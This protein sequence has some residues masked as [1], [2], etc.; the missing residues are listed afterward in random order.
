MNVAINAV[1]SF[2]T[3][4]LQNLKTLVLKKS[5]LCNRYNLFTQFN[6]TCIFNT[7]AF[8]QNTTDIWY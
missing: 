2:R 4:D 6:L 3:T 7:P 8:I 1:T 5:K